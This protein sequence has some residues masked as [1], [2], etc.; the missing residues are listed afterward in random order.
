MS[1]GYSVSWPDIRH[2]KT[3]PAYYKSRFEIRVAALGIK[4]TLTIFWLDEKCGIPSAHG[5][6]RVDVGRHLNM[7]LFYMFFFE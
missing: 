6:G 2:Q 1:S 3:D 4:A 7:D 5:R